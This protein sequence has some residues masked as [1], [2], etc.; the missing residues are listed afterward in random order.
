M[1]NSLKYY[2][3]FCEQLANANAWR[4]YRQGLGAKNDISIDEVPAMSVRPEVRAGR[5]KIDIV[6][7]VKGAFRNLFIND[8]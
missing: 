5:P 1:N 8:L 7:F 6:E 4:N 3:Y 2:Y